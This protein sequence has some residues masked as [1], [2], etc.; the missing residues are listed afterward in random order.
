MNIKSVNVL[1]SPY[2]Q[3]SSWHDSDDSFD[4]FVR[5]TP[6]F[7]HA[8]QPK[9]MAEVLEAWLAMRPP[10]LDMKRKSWMV[11]V[12]D[13]LDILSLEGGLIYAA[14]DSWILGIVKQVQVQK[15]VLSF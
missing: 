9:N 5:S 12:K 15:G 3:G 1:P 6:V 2:T 13:V 4:L 10:S 8:F 11:I 7:D 14:L